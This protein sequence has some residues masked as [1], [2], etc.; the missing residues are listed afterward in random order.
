MNRI[1][2]DHEKCTG[3]RICQLVCSQHFVSEGFNLKASAIRVIVKDLFEVDVPITCLQCKKPLCSEACP[4]NAFYR[5][6]ETNAVVIEVNKCIGCGKCAEACPF[7]AIFVHPY[8]IVPIKCDLC[9]GNP[10]CVQHCPTGAL[11]LGPEAL[12]GEKKIQFNEKHL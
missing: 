10:M 8:C 12:I 4:T 7:G 1:L 5:D 9:E 2:V 6:S 11:E 3:C